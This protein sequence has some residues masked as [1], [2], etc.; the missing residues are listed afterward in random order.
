MDFAIIGNCKSAAL[1]DSSGTINWLCLPEFDSP[2]LFGSLLDKDKG[3]CFGIKVD[4]SFK[5]EQRYIPNTNIV[6]TTFSG[7]SGTLQVID[8]MPRYKSDDRVYNCPPEVIRIVRLLAGKPRLSIAYQPCLGYAEHPTNTFAKGDFIKSTVSNDSYES[9]YLYTNADFDDVLQ[10]REFTLTGDLYF[11]ISYH[12]KLLPLSLERVHLEFQRTKV[13]W[14]EWINRS[15]NLTAY[16]DEVR[17]S[18]LVLKLLT[19]Q[20]SG[21]ILAAVTTSLPETIGEERNWDYRFCWIRDASMILRVMAK[22]GHFNTAHN[23]FNYIM[24]V[25]PFKDDKVQIMYGIRG[26]KDL[27]EHTLDWLAGYKDS[28]P[29]RVGNAAY[30]QKQNDIYGVLLDAIYRFTQTFRSDVATIERLWTITRTLVRTVSERW[31]EPDVGIWEFRGNTAHFVFS[32]VLCWVALDRGIK[33]AEELKCIDRY[34]GWI[35]I[36][37]NIKADVLAKGWNAEVGSFTQAY[38]NQFVDAANL[39]IADFGFV[40]FDDPRYISTVKVTRQRLCRNGLMYRY[41]NEDDFG[42]PQSSFTVCSFWM[43]KALWNIGERSDARKMFHQLLSYRNHLGLMSEDLDFETKEQLGNFPQ[44]YSH[45]ALIDCALSLC[46]GDFDD[47]SL[48]VDLIEN[49]QRQEEL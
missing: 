9:I 18:A 17:R 48:L 45:L 16:V 25:I 12:Q 47:E 49:I 10:G 31:Q 42:L 20:E 26:Q 6:E 35:T 23:F 3:G 24:R 34:Q 22:I 21:A 11:D 32:K 37:D 40:E 41:K 19:F 13:Y 36:R 28:K 7:D 14:L 39:L 15:L 29:V 1:I 33:I 43:V 27:T 46:E 5:I 8:F 44:G 4:P 38:D 2:S 30:T